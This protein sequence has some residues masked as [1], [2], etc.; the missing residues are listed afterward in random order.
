M[1]RF[2]AAEQEDWNDLE[3]PGNISVEEA[4]VMEETAI[5]QSEELTEEVAEANRMLDVADSMEDLAV[6]TEPIVEATPAETQLVQI[7]GDMAVAGSDEVTAE[8]LV[9]ATES[10]VGRRIASEAFMD[11]AREIWERI[12]QWLKEVWAKVEKF[13]Y[14]IFG[15]IPRAKKKLEALEKRIE[16]I[17]DDGKTLGKD[18]RTFDL[19]SGI[20]S[21]MVGNAP[22]K[23]AKG[24]LDGLDV[25]KQAV[26]KCFSKSTFT[27]ISDAI[28]KGIENFNFKNT[29]GAESSLTALNTALATALDTKGLPGVAVVTDSKFENQTVIAL[30]GVLGGRDLV[31]RFPK[32]ADTSKTSALQIAEKLRQ[33]RLEFTNTYKTVKEPDEIKFNTLSL[34]E[35]RDVIEKCQELLVVMEKFHRGSD[36]KEIL[37]GKDELIKASERFAKDW[38]KDFSDEESTTRR[39]IR[40]YANALIKYNTFYTTLCVT[41]TQQAF[42]VTRQSVNAAIMV[43]SRSLSQYKKAD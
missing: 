5:S 24:L 34:S 15:T 20:G 38:D 17:E 7:A 40:P 16:D 31:F 14:N 32:K 11:K 19:S 30:R 1:R 8:D 37:K 6:V 22:V 2:I 41:A 27:G 43:V 18:G 21:L 39:A 29:D 28:T 26:E 12:K 23:G 36:R 9:P 4:E 35:C 10:F 3:H 33:S 13:F 25:T 42:A